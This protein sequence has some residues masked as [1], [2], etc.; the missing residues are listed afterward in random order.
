[1]NGLLSLPKSSLLVTCKLMVMELCNLVDPSGTQLKLMKGLL[2]IMYST[3]IVLIAII[4][5]ELIQS[6]E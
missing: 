5:W 4:Q 6:G 3:E 1:M 2:V